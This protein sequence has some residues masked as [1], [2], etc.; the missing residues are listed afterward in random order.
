MGDETRISAPT[1]VLDRVT[2]EYYG[3]ALRIKRKALGE[4]HPQATERLGADCI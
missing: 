2:Q 3:K 4:E 1:E